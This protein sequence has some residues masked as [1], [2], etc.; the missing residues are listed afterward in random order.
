MNF[1]AVHEEHYAVVIYMTLTQFSNFG[2]NKRL[3]YVLY[4][5]GTKIIGSIYTS[6]RVNSQNKTVLFVIYTFSIHRNT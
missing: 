5:N 6:K 1:S 4:T 2:N 3:A